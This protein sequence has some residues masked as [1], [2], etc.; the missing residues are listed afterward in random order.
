MHQ[1][2]KKMIRYITDDLKYSSDDSNE[3][4]ET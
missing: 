1:K 3:F 4:D 2:R